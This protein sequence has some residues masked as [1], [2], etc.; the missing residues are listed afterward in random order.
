MYNESYIMHIFSMCATVQ[1]NIDERHRR[2]RNLFYD[3]AVLG[4]LVR[5]TFYMYQVVRSVDA[6]VSLK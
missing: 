3:P 6:S 4:K 2:V 5:V 1:E